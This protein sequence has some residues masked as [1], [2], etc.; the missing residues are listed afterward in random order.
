MPKLS[1]A[2][3]LDKIAQQKR[4]AEQLEARLKLIQRKEQS[5]STAEIARL[6]TKAGIDHLSADALYGCFLQIAEDAA[7]PEK[8]AAWEA[9]GQQAL[10]SNDNDQRVIGIARFASKPS[11]ETVTGLRK[12]GFRWNKLLGQWEGRIIFDEATAFVIGAGGIISQVTAVEPVEK[13]G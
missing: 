13:T 7:D 8:L 4:K 5:R 11:P 2:E 10:R 9:R 6:V 12:L 3:R 1:V